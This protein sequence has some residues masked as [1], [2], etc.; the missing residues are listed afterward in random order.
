MRRCCRGPGK[1]WLATLAV[2]GIFSFAA[3]GISAQD[4]QNDGPDPA[5]RDYL[6]ANG[7][8]NRGLYELATAEYRKF[9]SEHEDHEKRRSLATVWG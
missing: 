9:L 1:S 6:S 5:L 2:L 8:L 7:L 4:A 3:S